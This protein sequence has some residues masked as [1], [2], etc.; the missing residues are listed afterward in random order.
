M[1]FIGGKKGIVE[2]R[3]FGVTL[4]HNFEQIS[5]Q[6]ILDMVKIVLAYIV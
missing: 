3:F 2:I 4:I 6:F 5:K 1:G